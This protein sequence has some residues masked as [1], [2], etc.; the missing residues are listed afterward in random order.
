MVKL[1][2]NKT[3]LIQLRER[4]N[5]PTSFVPTMGN[6][7]QGHLSLIEHAAKKSKHVFISIFVNP[8]QFGPNEDFEKY[9][10]TL[11]EDIEKI[12]SLKLECNIYIFAP[13]SVSE[14]YPKGF[15]TKFEIP[16][17]SKSLCAKSKAGAF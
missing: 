2:K 4:I 14:V 5:E 10:R 11:K 16:E 9:P 3:D 15:S 13:Q 8:T 6:L 12:D 7:H 17:L 1:I